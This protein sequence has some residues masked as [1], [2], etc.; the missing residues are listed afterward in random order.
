MGT[1]LSP[2]Q[3]ATPDPLPRLRERLIA[4]YGDVVPR[5]RIDRTAEQALRELEGARIREFVP[6]FA[7]RRARAYMQQQAS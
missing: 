3:D 7:W 1:R 4:E 6:V 5:E 2:L